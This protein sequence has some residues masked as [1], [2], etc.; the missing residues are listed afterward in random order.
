MLKVASPYLCDIRLWKE[1][2]NLKYFCFTFAMSMLP[3]K[4]IPSQLFQGFVPH[5][6]KA[7]NR[8]IHIHIWAISLKKIFVI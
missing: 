5:E 7:Y 8:H 3:D 2:Q 6:P 1:V 4:W